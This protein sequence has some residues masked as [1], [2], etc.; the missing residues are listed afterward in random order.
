MSH[1]PS[2]P[3]QNE[4]SIRILHIED[5]LPDRELIAE[6]LSADGLP[7][8][9]IYVASER[10]FREA[11]HRTE[12][13]L[14]LSDFS[15]PTFDGASALQVARALRPDIPFLFVSGTI[16]ET[17]AIEALRAGATDYV[18]KNHLRRL[19]PAVRRALD[20][21]RERTENLRA[22]AQILHLNR[23][24]QVLNAINQLIVRERV[25]QAVLEGACRIA[26]EK[27]GFCLAWIGLLD[28]VEPALELV[29]S[30]GARLK[31]KGVVRFDLKAGE[32]PCTRAVLAG[33]HQVCNDLDEVPLIEPWSGAAGECGCHALAVFPLQITGKTIGV[34]ALY[35]AEKGV[36][37][38][39][40]LDL[41]DELVK[42]IAFALDH[43]QREQERQRM[44]EQLRASEERFR[45]LAETVQ[46][47]FW[48]TTPDKHR[49]LYVSPAYEKIWGRTCQSLYD[50]PAS[51]LDAIHPND[52]Q[53]IRQAAARQQTGGGYDEEYRIIRP[54]LQIRWVRD[55]AFPVYNAA[56]HVER[57][58]GVARDITERRQMA[59][60]L[61]QSQKMEAVGQLAGGVAHDFNNILAAIMLQSQLSAT[62][63]SVSPEVQE[64]LLQIYASAE[65]A[66]SLVRQLLLFSSKQI[67]QSRNLDLN[68]V[69]TSLVK[70]LQRVIGEHIHLQLQLHPAPLITHA[71]TCMLDQILVNLAVNSRD[72]MPGGGRL[73]V[74]T[75][76]QMFDEHQAQLQPDARTGHYVCLQVTDTGSG[77]PP[78]ILPRIF[79]PFFTTKE[80]GKGT[81][82]GLATVFGIVK[83]HGGFITV[84]SEPGRGTTF[85]I[86][87]PAREAAPESQAAPARSGVRCGSE[88]ILLVED[89]SSVRSLM[90]TTLSRRGYHVLEA[91]NG[92]QALDLWGKHQQRIALLVTDL[93]MPAGLSGQELAGRLQQEKPQLKVI[94]TSGYS[95]ETAGG[96]IFLKPDENFL[97]KPFPLDHFL[98]NVRRC[99]DED[100]GGDERSVTPA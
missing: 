21:A 8:E 9:I 32:D 61:R 12:F 26:V 93:V 59:E 47:V 69:V 37:S 6:G 77:I 42:D 63:E 1:P 18:L 95:A 71:D 19:G 66:S 50:F 62:S 99:L 17:R 39:D 25:P 65:R 31:N 11:L 87:I 91:A 2:Q 79:E 53:R 55:T 94:F 15:T 97:Q 56:G 24:Y 73:L 13:D 76:G 60:Q 16:G 96:Q 35:A 72:A 80:P 85:Q 45:E 49:M 86:F 5:S 92:V 34:L 40:E 82:L 22:A 48:I 57:V 78:E 83:Q 52:R 41:L 46:E 54:D 84:E 10:E 75:F 29:A 7:C 23:T 90:R 14:I 64:G 43:G 38:Q 30:A 98:E 58:V 28:P 3:A 36:F 88:T 70:M 27:G 33:Q 68:A 81:G 89:D 4:R 20:E 44:V 51:W 67:M 74:R 100:P